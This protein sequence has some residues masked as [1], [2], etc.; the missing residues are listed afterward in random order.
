[1]TANGLSW[2][3][4]DAEEDARRQKERIIAA[5][6]RNLRCGK[7]DLEVEAARLLLEMS[8]SVTMNEVKKRVADLEQRLTH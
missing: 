2:R 3:Q 5:L 7:P 6:E 8:A 4:I 1:M